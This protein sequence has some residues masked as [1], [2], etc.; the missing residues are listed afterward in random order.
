M[1]CPTAEDFELEKRFKYRTP[2]V[3]Y[4]E[5]RNFLHVQDPFVWLGLGYHARM[6]LT[7]HTDIKDLELC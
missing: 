5:I 2:N 4:D 7:F 3:S 1:R 6:E